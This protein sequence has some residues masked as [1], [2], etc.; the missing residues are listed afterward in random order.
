MAGEWVAAPTLVACA[1]YDHPT[2]QHLCLSAPAQLHPV[3]S[4]AIMGH[5]HEGGP[6][7][8]PPGDPSSDLREFPPA[9]P[10]L[11][12]F[13]FAARPELCNIVIS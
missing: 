3:T 8:R 9:R 5:R 7:R 1:S 2:L 4:H 12:P 6:I 11:A 10:R 13:P